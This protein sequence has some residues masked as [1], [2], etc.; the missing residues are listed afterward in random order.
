MKCH[1]YPV[2]SIDQIAWPES[3]TGLSLDSPALTLLTDFQYHQPRFVDGHDS[4]SAVEQAMLRTHVR[5]QLVVDEHHQFLGLVS[6]D[7]LNGQEILKR[8]AHGFKRSDLA[9]K[10]FMRPR[11]A[12]R[13]LDYEELRQARVRDL[14]ETLKNKEHQHYLVVDRKSHHIRGVISASDIARKLRLD[15]KIHHGS[16]FVAIYNALFSEVQFH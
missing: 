11:G 6:L 14:V 16:S 5:L 3:S 13:A 1:L 9:A 7:D 2:D 10:D 12:L 15:I 8:V 4:A